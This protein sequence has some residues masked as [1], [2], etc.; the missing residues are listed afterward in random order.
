M[1]LF[2]RRR[3]GT[4]EA[5][6]IQNVTTQR[7]TNLKNGFPKVH[8]SGIECAIFRSRNNMNGIK[9]IATKKFES[10]FRFLSTVLKILGRVT[11]GFGIY[12]QARIRRTLSA[13]LL[14]SAL[15]I[16]R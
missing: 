10:A 6:K 3:E 1:A 13:L 15:C 8:R 14:L 12:I 9:S 5:R 16:V 4:D 2:S 11:I 7:G